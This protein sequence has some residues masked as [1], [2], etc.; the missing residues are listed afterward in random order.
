MAPT[1]V[2][3]AH[4]IEV[5]ERLPKGP[6]ANAWTPSLR[7][8]ARSKGKYM[9]AGEPGFLKLT[10]AKKR[11]LSPEYASDIYSPACRLA[12]SREKIVAV[13][14]SSNVNSATI[15]DYLESAWTK[16][17]CDHELFEQ[18][19]NNDHSRSVASSK[20]SVNPAVDSKLST[21]FNELSSKNSVKNEEE[22]RAKKAALVA[23]QKRAVEE[24][25]DKR[26][27]AI[28]RRLHDLNDDQVLDCSNMSDGHKM[29]PLTVRNVSECTHLVYVNQIAS[30]NMPRFEALARFL[31]SD[32]SASIQEFRTLFHERMH[33]KKEKE[34]VAEEVKPVEI[35]A[36]KM[37]VVPAKP[38][39]T[40]PLPSMNGAGR[41]VNANPR[42][43][44]PRK[45]TTRR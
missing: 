42:A 39:L 21:I 26:R 11:W 2:R 4:F 14:R 28:L 6:K 15:D 10:N 45:S 19:C 5:A 8:L 27:K 29:S 37:T 44:S 23:A 34:V 12:G 3:S 33:A 16:D 25:A 9:K 36:K 13:L 41:T 1:P 32:Y 31:G 17:N 24:E 35:S 20:T 18:D 22:A 38:T 30:D 43:A 40:K 7:D